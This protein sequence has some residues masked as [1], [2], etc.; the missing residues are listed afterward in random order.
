MYAPRNP[1]K[2]AI[3]LL[4]IGVLALSSC[5]LGH[6]SGD[7]SAA[8]NEGIITPPKGTGNVAALN[9]RFSMVTVRRG[10]LERSVRLGVT[11]NFANTRPLSFE[12]EGGVYMDSLIEN[13][14]TRVLKGDVLAVQEFPES[15]HEPLE[16]ARTRMKFQIEQFEE[17][18]I[19]EYNDRARELTRARANF[20]RLQIRRL[21]LTQER[22]LY[23]SER[24]RL[25]FQRQLD[26]MYLPGEH[27]YA[28][29]DGLITFV[30]TI[31]PEFVNPNI[32]LF[33]IADEDSLVFTAQTSAENLRHGNVVTIRGEHLEFDA[34]VV[35]DSLAAPGRR[36]DEM[37]FTLLPL[38]PE[39]L[40]KAMADFAFHELAAMNLYT[41][42]EEVVVHDALLLPVRAIRQE[43]RANYVVIY[44]DGQLLKRYVARGLQVSPYVQILMGVEEGQRVVL[45]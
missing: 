21:E 40:A 43:D 35:S 45:P 29:F 38:D 36:S 15:F 31:R 42:I 11:A 44:N 28:P 2:F 22:F 39:A 37:D 23:E 26:D 33:V 14:G 9:E 27:I 13:V 41:V 5:G 1:Y 6:S 4:I 24:T 30:S 25:E 3:V 16:I 8:I 32:V 12:V 10:S 17:R 20:N 34:K 7:I 19:N 18:F